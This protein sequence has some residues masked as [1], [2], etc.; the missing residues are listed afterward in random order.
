MF[1]STRPTILNPYLFRVEYL[2][3]IQIMLRFMIN[4]RDGC[5]NKYIV[6]L[7]TLKFIFVQV[8]PPDYDPDVVYPQPQV[9]FRMFDYT[10]VYSAEEEEEEVGSSVLTASTSPSL[11]G[12]HTIERFLVDEQIHI[13]LE[14][15]QFSRTMW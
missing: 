8:T 4:D 2:R 13:I 9:I 12:A 15:M 3:V 1:S 14:T 6:R 10:D 11:P 7:L 5:I